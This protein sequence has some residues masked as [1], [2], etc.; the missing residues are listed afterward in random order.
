MRRSPAVLAA[1]ALAACGQSPGRSDAGPGGGG[2]LVFAVVGDTRPAN[3]C[4]STASCPYPTAIAAQIYK[5]LS[6]VSPA[7]QLVV[8]TGDYMYNEPGA[9][10]AS[11][12]IQQYLGA[13]TQLS[14]P[15]YPTMGNHECTGYTASECG[16]GNA[17]GVT[18]NYTAF[19]GDLLGGLKLPTAA[20][21]YVETVPA[22]P[23]QT[24]KFVFVAAN[25]WTDAQAT[26][27]DQTLSQATTYT[28]VVRHEPSYDARACAGI[29]ASDQIIQK[30]PLTLKLVGHSHEYR[31]Y[32]SSYQEVVV[33]NGGAPL[34]YG[35][36][37]F[38]LCKQ[39]SDGAIQCEAYDYQ[40]NA[41]LGQ[42]FALTA[43][44]QTTSV[45]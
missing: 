12:Q 5:D 24:A 31:S 40:S 18:E 38:V 10:T 45:Q 30:H 39:R 27:L 22:G 21:Y 17:D 42:A 20:P 34:A 43:S 3:P 26:W 16:E 14:V 19:L 29:P 41:P 8:A 15:I 7:P 36:Y 1:V 28:F 6:E 35:S 9:G 44:G 13:A 11:W 25:A 2:P 33:G 37:G 4:P 23:G 32:E